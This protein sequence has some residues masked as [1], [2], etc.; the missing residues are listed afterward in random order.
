MK[1]TVYKNQFKN[2][3]KVVRPNNF[4][5]EGLDALYEYFEEYEN[6][7]GEEIELD[8][9]AICCEYAEYDNLQE[10]QLDYGHEDYPDVESIMDNACVIQFGEGSFIISSF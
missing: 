10:F 2:A 4:S 8:V 1:Q 5:N 6:S 9:I 7:T 3:F